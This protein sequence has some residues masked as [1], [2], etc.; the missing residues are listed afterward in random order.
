MVLVL[1]PVPNPSVVCAADGEFS[2]MLWTTEIKKL[3]VITLKRRHDVRSCAAEIAV[4][5]GR[6]RVFHGVAER[7]RKRISVQ[8]TYRNRARVYTIYGVAFKAAC[9]CTLLIGSFGQKNVRKERL[10]TRKPYLFFGNT[11]VDVRLRT[12]SGFKVGRQRQ[13][14]VILSFWLTRNQFVRWTSPGEKK[15]L[16]YTSL[17]G[18]TRSLSKF[19]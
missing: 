12:K 10:E 13:W 8:N 7:F 17:C 1:T 16:F 6:V 11:R 15:L 14:R 9:L 18:L 3:H 5:V 2:M 4:V 19:Q